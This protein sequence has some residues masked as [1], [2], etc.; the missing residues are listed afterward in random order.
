VNFRNY[1]RQR[2]KKKGP[3]YVAREP[4]ANGSDTAVEMPKVSTNAFREPADGSKYLKIFENIFAA[5]LV[6]KTRDKGK[7]MTALR[8][9][10]VECVAL[11][12]AECARFQRIHESL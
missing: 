12:S 9:I 5:R 6:G 10:F 7:R 4:A 2:T 11:S 8:K 3:T 1:G